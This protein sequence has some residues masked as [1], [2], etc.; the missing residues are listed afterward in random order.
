MV[1]GIAANH[2]TGPDN[3]KSWLTNIPMGRFGK[4]SEIANVICFLLSDESSFMSGQ[5]IRVGGGEGE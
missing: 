1:A 3:T 5:A 4:P 2:A